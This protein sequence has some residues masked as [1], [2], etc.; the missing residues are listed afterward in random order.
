MFTGHVQ[1]LNI[2]TKIVRH[3]FVSIH[4]KTLLEFIRK[5]CNFTVNLIF[6]PQNVI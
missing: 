1:M 3:E 4:C 2:N 6:I 5:L